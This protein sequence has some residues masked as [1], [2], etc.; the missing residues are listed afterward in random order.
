MDHNEIWRV[1]ITRSSSLL[2]QEYYTNYP[3]IVA[4]TNTLSTK[5]AKIQLIV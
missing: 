4:L 3:N 2:F 5:D 1:W